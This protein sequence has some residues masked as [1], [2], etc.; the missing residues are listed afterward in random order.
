MGISDC[1]N[2]GL[3]VVPG[4]YLLGR[5]NIES[6]MNSDGKINFCLKLNAG[7]WPGSFCLC[8]LYCQK[9]NLSPGYCGFRI[10]SSPWLHL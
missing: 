3:D 6:Q 9:H 2:D 1:D 4:F 5:K 8:P 10:L 7:R